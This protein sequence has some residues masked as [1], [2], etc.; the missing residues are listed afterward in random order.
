M[1][2]NANNN[3]YNLNSQNSPLYESYHA[4]FAVWRLSFASRPAV[5]RI[6]LQHVVDACLVVTLANLLSH[7]SGQR[8]KITI[9]ILAS[10]HDL[11]VRPR[12]QEQH[13]PASSPYTPTGTTTGHDGYGPDDT[14]NDCYDLEDTDEDCSAI[15]HRPNNRGI[16][17]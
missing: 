14:A 10:L 6:I 13:H 11:Y 7:A 1:S 17:Q 3:V 8:L 5:V 12:D 16:A 15:A 2:V 4:L 9:V